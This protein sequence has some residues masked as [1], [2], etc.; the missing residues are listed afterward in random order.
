MSL[1][2]QRLRFVLAAGDAA[3]ARRALERDQDV[4]DLDVLV[5]LLGLRHQ[6]L[7]RCAI[8]STEFKALINDG[9]A[10]PH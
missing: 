9:L 4:L 10:K 7:D 5:G 3:H 8:R 2:R 6:Q 1:L